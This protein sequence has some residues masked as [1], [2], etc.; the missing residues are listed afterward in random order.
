MSTE[1]TGWV[2]VCDTE[3]CELAQIEYTAQSDEAECGGC[4]KIFTRPGSV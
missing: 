1:T 2:F 3:G 4:G